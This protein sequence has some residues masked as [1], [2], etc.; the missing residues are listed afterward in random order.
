MKKVGKLYAI[1][2]G[3]GASDLMTLRAAKLLRETDVVAV[4]EKTA[5]Q[6]DSFAWAIATG[7]VTPEE[8]QGE[9]LFLHF[10]MSRDV[11]ITVPAWQRAA[12]AIITRLKQGLDV[13]F[14]TEGDPSVFSTWAYLQEELAESLPDVE[15]EIVPGVSSITAVPAATGVPLADGEERFCVVPATYGIDMLPSLIEEFDTIIL[16]KAGRIVEPLIA[17]LEP[18]GLLHCARYV[19]YASGDNQEVYEDLRDVPK[20]HR[21]FA[22]IQLSIRGRKGRLRHGK[23]A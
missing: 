19:S 17:L 9:T 8:I 16:I 7:A 12:T 6:Q 15:V 3:P 5:G 10:P 21:Y 20:E 2:V 11:S 14:I 18:M 13:A 23:V 1:G 4:P 22:M